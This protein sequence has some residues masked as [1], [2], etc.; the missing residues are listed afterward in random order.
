MYI[1]LHMKKVQ[2]LGVISNSYTSASSL[3]VLLN[4]PASML[5]FDEHL[6]LHY[7]VNK[8]IYYFSEESQY[9]NKI[10]EVLTKRII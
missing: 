3:T 7:K 4:I 2:A 9:Q 1:A 10:H 5:L 8:I 6:V